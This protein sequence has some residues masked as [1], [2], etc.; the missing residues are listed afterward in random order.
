MERH[1]EGYKNYKGTKKKGYYS[2]VKDNFRYY[3]EKFGAFYPGYFY[4][5]GYRLFHLFIMRFLDYSIFC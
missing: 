1:F 4:G 3:E 2:K 5:S